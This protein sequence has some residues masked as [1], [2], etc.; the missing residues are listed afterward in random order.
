LAWSPDGHLVAAAAEKRVIVIPLPNGSPIEINLDSATLT[1]LAFSPDGA[2]LAAGDR[3]GKVFVVEAKTGASVA[4]FTPKDDR[5]DVRGLRFSPDGTKLAGAARQVHLWSVAER[6]EICTADDSYIDGFAFSAKGDRFSGAGAVQWASWQLADCKRLAHQDL[7]TGG[8]FPG[9]ISPDGA[10]VAA[11]EG[12]GHGLNVYTTEP[13]ARRASLPG[14]ASCEDHVTILGFGP[15]GALLSSGSGRWVRTYKPRT[16]QHVGA[17]QA[18]KVAPPAWVTFFHD[19]RRFLAVAEDGAVSAV[20]LATQKVDY[21]LDAKSPQVI[22][23]SP[24][25]AYI[26]AATDDALLVWE[27]KEGQRLKK[28]VPSPIRAR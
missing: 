5:E 10:F 19:G 6:R 1:Q 21:T 13:W 4:T 15:D 28:L 26:A 24:D 23:V 22:E 16:F 17:W 3:E 20:S 11:S 25:D 7:A 27:A 8:T 2:R 9:V 12:D 14:A 18:G